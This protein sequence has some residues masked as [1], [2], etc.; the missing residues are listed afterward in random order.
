[1]VSGVHGN[2]VAERCSTFRNRRF[3]MII[4]QYAVFT[5]YSTRSCVAGVVAV[6][7]R[8]STAWDPTDLGDQPALTVL[9]HA[10]L[11][12]GDNACTSCHFRTSG[13]E[14]VCLDARQ[15]RMGGVK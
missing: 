9:P 8:G 6:N 14:P 4:G 5:H 10:R 7:F 12:V 15:K 2:I 13:V 3:S 1:L 11:S